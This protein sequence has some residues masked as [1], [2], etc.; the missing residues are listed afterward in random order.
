M[1]KVILAVVFALT[2]SSV[3][4]CGGATTTTAPKAGTPAK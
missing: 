2:V 1:K 3:V 4:G